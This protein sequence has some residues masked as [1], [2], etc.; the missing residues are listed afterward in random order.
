[1]R[2]FVLHERFFLNLG[3]LY[4]ELPLLLV[5]NEVILRSRGLRYNVSWLYVIQFLKFYYGYT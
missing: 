5:Y 3:V 4:S 2:L 1:M